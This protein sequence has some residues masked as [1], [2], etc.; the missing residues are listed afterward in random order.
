[1]ETHKI[2]PKLA[3][4]MHTLFIKTLYRVTEYQKA[5]LEDKS[6]IFAP[7]HTN[8]LDGYIIWSLLAKDYDVDTF[9]FKEFWDNFP[10]IA[11]LLP[12]FNVYP[13]TRDSIK[14]DEILNEIRKLK[15][16]NHSLIIFPQGRHVD[17]EVMLNFK[18]YHLNTIPFGA[19]YIAVKAS[20]KLVPIYMEPQKLGQNNLVIYGNPLDPQD[21]SLFSKGK[22]QKENL[23]MF[24]NAWLDE[25]I[26][27]YK[28]AKQLKG[29][30][31]HPYVIE[32]S[33]TDASGL[34]YGLLEDPNIAINFKKI[35][36]A[37]IEISKKTGITDIDELGKIANISEEDI[38]AISSLRDIYEKRLVRRR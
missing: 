9:M 24:A 33:Y 7:N 5:L 25:I 15:D 4:F 1:M 6:Y 16:P 2:N 21:F 29:E 17:P 34:D 14:I 27:L 28:N 23:I 32:S 22:M 13:I 36:F 20:K 18:E 3:L 19:F 38:L 37:L 11:K 12:Y 31:L 35:I 30:K 10:T 8:N 26:R